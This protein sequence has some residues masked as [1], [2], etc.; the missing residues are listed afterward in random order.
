MSK[1]K[2]KIAANKRPAI[3][4]CIALLLIVAVSIGYG[5]TA[6][7]RTKKAMEGSIKI[8]SGIVGKL[9]MT[10][11]SALKNEDGTYRLGKDTAKENEYELLPGTVIE[12]D[13]QIRIEDKSSAEAYLYLEV[14]D[15]LDSENTKVT[16]AL[17]ESWKMVEGVTGLNNGSIYVYAP[18]GTP[19]KLAKDS[20]PEAVN[21]FE[22]GVA[23]A[24]D[25]ETREEPLK[26]DFCAYMAK[27]GGK[28]PAAAFDSAIHSDTSKSSF[29]FYAE[30]EEAQVKAE[31]TDN[32]ASN[33][34]VIVPETGYS[35][36]VRALVTVSWVNADGEP[37]DGV[38]RE[39]VNYSATYGRGWFNADGYWYYESTVKS[40]GKTSYL[41]VSISPMG[42]LAERGARLVVDVAPEMIQAGGTTDGKTPFVTAEWA[43][44]LNS[45]GIII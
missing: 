2:E 23:A 11:H 41:I 32:S 1:L 14:V 9:E 45:K 20:C 40:G 31:T 7:Y 27:C 30:P 16:F 39:G 28:D 19:A 15:E 42:E 43:R 26:L 22:D 13:L 37:L 8:E 33:V 25:L 12:R 35:V 5:V 4:I 34:C 38:P 3:M 6:K 24:A 36:Y 18:G 44:K 29:G 21:V 10:E 17:D